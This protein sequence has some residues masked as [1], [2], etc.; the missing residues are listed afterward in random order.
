MIHHCFQ[1][2]AF[3]AA[4]PSLTV[5]FFIFLCLH[6][7]S[8]QPGGRAQAGSNHLCHWAWVK[9]LMAHSTA[10]WLLL[11]ASV[12]LQTVRVVNILC[13]LFTVF[14]V[15]LAASAG[16]L[17]LT[18]PPVQHHWESKLHLLSDIFQ[19]EVTVLIFKIL[20]IN[21]L[22]NSLESAKLS[23]VTAWLLLPLTGT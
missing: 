19:L 8:I 17:P 14:S 5:M 11:A 1:K 9:R 18:L 12:P 2:Y 3:L 10:Q 22:F 13:H 7:V 4:T 6:K 15:A 23:S 20:S 21:K 16:Q